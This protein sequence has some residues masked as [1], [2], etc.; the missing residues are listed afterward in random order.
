M[1]VARTRHLPASIREVDRSWAG[2]RS[3]SPTSASTF[4]TRWRLVSSGAC[5]PEE[6]RVDAV[7][8]ADRAGVRLVQASVDR[9]GVEERVVIA[10][11]E[12]IPFE[13]APLTRSMSQRSTALPGVAQHAL[14]VRPASA[15]L[16][17]RH[18]IQMR[19]ETID[20]AAD[21][22]VVGGGTLGMELAF[23]LLS[24]LRGTPST[25][26]VVTIVD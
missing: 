22:V 14:H 15:L 1:S 26:G 5:T 18:A 12:R 19:L 7:A 10:G 17:L 23:T 2:D 9:I 24:G 25:G 3:S 4:T 6:L 20:R 21:C 16:G 13:P 8:L 11:S